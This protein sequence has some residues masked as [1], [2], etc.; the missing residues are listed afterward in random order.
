MAEHQD[1]STLLGEENDVKEGCSL[2]NWFQEDVRTVCRDRRITTTQLM[3]GISWCVQSSCM[4]V[5][6]GADSS[7]N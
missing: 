2:Q 5:E 4:R 3:F 1:L 7:T 6:P